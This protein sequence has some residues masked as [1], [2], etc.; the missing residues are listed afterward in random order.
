MAITEKQ[1]TQ[2][3]R[4]Y[5]NNKDKAREQKRLVMRSLRAANPEKYRK[6]ANDCNKRQ[7]DKV[8][9]IYGRICAVC[10]FG[11]IRALTLDHVLNNG[12]EERDMIGERGVYRRSILPEYRHEYQTLCMNCQFI[13]RHEANRLNQ[14]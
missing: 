5:E 4:W 11:D 3:Q 8:F 10:G 9:D 6:H 12:A 14:H 7:K 2:Y 13:K 1:K